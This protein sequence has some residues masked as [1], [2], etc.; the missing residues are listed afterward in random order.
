MRKGE[1][2][3]GAI[4]ESIHYYKT[5]GLLFKLMNRERILSTATTDKYP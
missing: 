5:P 2:D 3:V 1:L 4:L